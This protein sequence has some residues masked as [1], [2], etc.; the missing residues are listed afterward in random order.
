MSPPPPPTPQSGPPPL[1]P[2]SLPDAAPPHPNTRRPRRPPAV[3][4]PAAASSA[5]AVAAATP[6]TTTRPSLH[7]A[8]PQPD[9]PLSPLPWNSCF[10]NST[11]LSIPHR[12]ATFRMYDAGFS[13]AIPEIAVVLLHGGGHAALSWA[14]VTTHLKPYVA[15]LAFDARGHGHSVTDEDAQLDAVT[16]VADA[17][18]VITKFFEHRYSVSTPPR[19]VVVGH[20]MGGAIAV[21]LAA[22]RLLNIAGLVVI[23]VVEGTALDALPHMLGWLSARTQSFPSVERAVRYVLRAGHVRN[24]QSARLS[25]P[26]QVRYSD[27]HRRWVWRTPLAVSQKYWRGWFEGLSALFLSVPAA[28]MLVLANVNRLDKDLMIAQMQGKFQNILIPAAGHTIHEDQPEQTAKVLLD[29]LQRNLFIDRVDQHE[30][31]VFQQREP[32]LPCC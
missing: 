27:E 7:A 1:H 18:A 25:V 17:A 6:T 15:T 22:A 12:K 8:L 24:P 4:S 28:K 20:S 19:L 3:P 26:A 32:V 21:R 23:D 13:E 16:Q 9:Q 2:S 30:A 31:S 11:D 10:D 5:A 14:L 29:Y